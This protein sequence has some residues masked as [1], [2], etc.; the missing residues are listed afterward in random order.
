MR[1]LVMRHL[2][3]ACATNSGCSIQAA[4]G[5]LP[6]LLLLLQWR[7]RASSEAAELRAALDAAG[8]DKAALGQQLAVLKTQLSFVLQVRLQHRHLHSC[9]WVCK[10][11]QQL[12]L[13]GIAAAVLLTAVLPLTAAA[14]E[15]A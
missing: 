15:R 2:V 13:R 5:R 1:M 8:R 11:E 10:R 7:S 3:V 12:L 14:G 6:L 9:S 4:V